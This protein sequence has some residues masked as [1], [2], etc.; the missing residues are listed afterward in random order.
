M[1]TRI[2]LALVV[3]TGVASA[4][5]PTIEIGIYAP[6]VE[7]GTATARLAYGQGLAKAI[8]QATGIKTNA[9][10]YASIGALKKA[11]PDFAIV[12]G[13]CLATN[14]GSW[15]ILANAQ[16]DG[17]TSRTWGLYTNGAANM[18]ALRGKK[19]AYM[20]TGC[21]DA[22]FIDNAMLDTEVDPTFFGGRAPEKDLTGA[23]AA[24]ASYKTAQ[25]VFAPASAVNGKGLTKLFD[26]GSV[27]N[28]AFVQIGSKLPGST[29]Q[30]VGAAVVAYGGAG[31]ISGWTKPSRDPYASL[32]GALAPNRKQGVFA[33]PE[34]GR[35]DS[36]AVLVDPATIKDPH[37]V[38]VRH[39][40]QRPSSGRME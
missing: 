5:A 28:P 13:V 8:E 24:V 18:Q 32:Q 10:A 25:A 17:A 12:D 38:A 21:N 4:Q 6:S 30:K 27:P 29:G 23:V 20:S 40:Y 26:T 2:I 11:N 15:T 34:A 3:L 1:V 33:Y 14:L 35:I 37:Y 22:G 39:Q 31:A 36:N 9:Q 19:L 16:V 7:F